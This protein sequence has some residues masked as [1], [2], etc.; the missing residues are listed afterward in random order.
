HS[1]PVAEIDLVQTIGDADLQFL[2]LADRPGGIISALARAGIDRS[3]WLHR[4]QV[5]DD[6]GLLQPVAAQ[7]H[8]APPPAQYAAIFDMRGMADEEQNSRHGAVDTS[9]KRSRMCRPNRPQARP[10]PCVGTP[11][12]RCGH[13]TKE[14]NPG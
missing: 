1:G 10:V 12:F 14:T 9:M 4:E 13:G 8:V 7:R 6:F 3:E 11:P 2:R 5:G